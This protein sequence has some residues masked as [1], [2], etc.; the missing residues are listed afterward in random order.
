MMICLMYVCRPKGAQ[1]LGLSADISHKH[2][3]PDIAYVTLLSMEMILSIGYKP[4]Q[5]VLV[6]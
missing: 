2:D 1:C 4:N 5:G 6:D 3:L